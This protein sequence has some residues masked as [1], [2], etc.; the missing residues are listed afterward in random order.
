IL[1]QKARSLIGASLIVEDRLIG[2][3]HTET[4]RVRRFT[5]DDARLL[6][7]GADRVAL[8][9]EQSRLYEVELQARRQAEEANHMKDEFLALVSP[10]TLSPLNAILG[11]ASLLRHGG[12]D[13]QKAKQ[14]L[15]VIERSGKA[16]AL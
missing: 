13:A 14:A 11:Y 16:Q 9:I 10:E 7:L 8:A 12:V 6:R 15:D 1:R 5:E 4:T 2:V 3:I